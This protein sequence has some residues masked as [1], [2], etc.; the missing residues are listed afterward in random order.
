MRLEKNKVIQLRKDDSKNKSFEKV[1]G[2]RLYNEG[3]RFY[4]T[5][6]DEMALNKFLQS[7]KEGYESADMFSFISWIYLNI[8]KDVDK[9]FLY[10]E[11][12]V[13]LDPEYGYPYQVKGDCYVEKEDGD[14]ALECYLKAE[15]CEQYSEY[16]F[17]QITWI[18][19]S[20]NNFLK[21]H[22]YASKAIKAAP[23]SGRA[24]NL[25]GFVYYQ[26]ED[27]KNAL[28]YFLKAEKY[29]EAN[30]DLFYNISYSYSLTDCHKKA[31]EYANKCVF[32]D[33]ENSK[34][35]YRKGFAYFQAGEDKL[36]IEPFLMA[37]KYGCTEFDM[38]VRLAYLYFEVK[39][40]YEKALE[41][42]DIGIKFG[43]KE[44]EA[45]L[46]K[47]NILSMTGDR[48]AG[49]YFKK[50]QKYLKAPDL[51]FILNYCSYLCMW[52][53]YKKALGIMNE[54]L[55]Y[56][57]DDYYMTMLKVFSL[58][59]LK[60]FNDAKIWVG[61][62]CHLEPENPINLYVRACVYF[63]VDKNYSKVIELMK[64]FY[65]D[66]QECMQG[67]FELLSV[68]YC[69]LKEYEKSLESLYEFAKI[70]FYQ[71]YEAK[72]DYLDFIK[73][74]KHLLKRYPNDERLQVF[75]E[76]FSKFLTTEK[77]SD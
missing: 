7:E 49:K 22:E 69:K 70:Y 59:N 57:P 50:A 64:D 52:H 34:G 16:L 58:V 32:L 23:D 19:G 56:F 24:H 33:K 47:A 30:F 37:E 41:Y 20:Q 42:A 6:K 63:E 2:F 14:N 74:Y 25:K 76:K 21:A 17:N 35:Y 39:K 28:K 9:A 29:G 11:K 45:Y 60:R 12:A 10:A 71:P 36:A 73:T 51:P 27:Y 43:K 26:S 13:C 55:E 15:N 75:A 1:P 77:D 67:K 72:R 18:Y 8:K 31:I 61:K 5:N 4:R 66:D 68:S 3:L 40:F 48:S 54:G 44:F 38:Y 62:L 65:I 53:Y 46:M